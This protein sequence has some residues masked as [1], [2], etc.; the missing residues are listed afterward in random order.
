MEYPQ[1]LNNLWI[2]TR[3]EYDLKFIFPQNYNFNNKLFGVIDYTT[4]IFNIVWFLIIFL[5]VN[6][7][8]SSLIIKIIIGII[9]YFPVLLLSI[10]GFNGEN[11]VYVFSYLFNFVKKQKIYFYNK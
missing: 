8:F 6:I 2:S 3:K 4:A 9:F 10:I 7:F 1:I 5:L 11:I